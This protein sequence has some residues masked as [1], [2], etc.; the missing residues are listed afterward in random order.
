M[1]VENKPKDTGQLKAQSVFLVCF[2]QTPFTYFGLEQTVSST[3]TLARIFMFR[4]DCNEFVSSHLQPP[5]SHNV[6][7]SKYLL[8]LVTIP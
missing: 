1:Q 5:A 4:I 3:V 2:Q 8:K 6:T 7:G